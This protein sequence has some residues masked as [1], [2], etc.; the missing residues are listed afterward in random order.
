ME[1]AAQGRDGWMDGWMEKKNVSFSESKMLCGVAVGV[2]HNCVY[3]HTQESHTHDK[4]LV[5]HVRVQWI[6]ETQ[7]RACTVKVIPQL[8]LR[9]TRL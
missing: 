3:T 5:V 6:T 1:A 8:A 7:D 4:D 9:T 2:P